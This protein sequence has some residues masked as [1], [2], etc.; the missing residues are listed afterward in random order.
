VRCDQ[1][2]ALG[3]LSIT[4]FQLRIAIIEFRIAINQVRLLFDQHRSQDRNVVDVVDVVDVIGVYAAHD[5]QRS[6]SHPSCKYFCATHALPINTAHQPL[7]LRR[8][9]RPHRIASTRP[10]K[11]TL[12]QT[13][14]RQPHPM[15]IHTQHLDPRPQTIAE[16]VRTTLHRVAPQRYLRQPPQSIHAAA[17][18]HRRPRQPP[19]RRPQHARNS[20]SHRDNASEDSDTGNRIITPL[21]SNTSTVTA[22]GSTA[23]ASTTTG[24]NAGRPDSLRHQY[25]NV[26][27]AT[28]CRT[29]HAR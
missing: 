25:P 5:A 24:N 1:R 29:H 22:E 21:P 6:N 3:K 10:V 16:N 27:T 19:P 8:I 9:Q 15:R 11:A 13:T 17:Q 23:C 18:I 4:I 20:R 28:P 12:M 14:H 26:C 2:I 7:E